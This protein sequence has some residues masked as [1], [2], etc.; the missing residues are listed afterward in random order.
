MKILYLA[1]GSSQRP[2]RENALL[3]VSESRLFH[4]SDYAVFQPAGQ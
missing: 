2:E 4:S 1:L 3:K